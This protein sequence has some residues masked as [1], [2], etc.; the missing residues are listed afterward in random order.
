MFCPESARIHPV[1]RWPPDST[2][3]AP[4]AACHD[5]VWPLVPESAVVKVSGAARVYVP[6]PSCTTMSPVIEGAAARTAACAWAIEQ[7]WAAVQA[8]PDPVGDTE[9]VV[10]TAAAAGAAG[11]M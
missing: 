11:L 10:M 5:T 8:V 4:G 3:R 6:V 2:G 9:R 7:G 1:T